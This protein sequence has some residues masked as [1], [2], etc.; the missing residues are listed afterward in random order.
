[1]SSSR[2]RGREERD[3]AVQVFVDAVPPAPAA[4]PANS[5]VIRGHDETVNQVVV[6]PESRLIVTAC[7][8]GHVRVFALDGDGDA[9]H[10]LDAH[11]GSNLKRGA[12]GLAALG[13][14]IIASAGT[15]DGV[16]STWLASSGVFLE[17]LQL[18]R[19]GEGFGTRHG[20]WTMA[21][22]GEREDCLVTSGFEEEIS[23]VSHSDGRKLRVASVEPS[24]CGVIYTISA[25]RDVI[26]AGGTDGTVS[27]FSAT[28]CKVI[29]LLDGHSD[30]TIS[31]AV[32]DRYIAAISI[33]K[34]MIVY[35]NVEGYHLVIVPQLVEGSGGIVPWEGEHVTL[36]GNDL[37]VSATSRQ[38]EEG[39]G[40]RVWFSFLPASQDFA[41]VDVY[42]DD[43][44]SIAITA[45]GTLACVGSRGQRALIVTP[46]APVRAAIKKHADLLFGR[47]G[48]KSVIS[49]MRLRSLGIRSTLK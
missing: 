3:G 25:Q 21:A 16:V 19:G 12:C 8:E 29:A 46:P 49:F 13:G 22:V 48:T 15:D 33:S 38:L 7:C 23:F 36:V 5:R 30:W 14:D 43:I 4:T 2:K 9:L 44:C 11:S 1:M 40:S 6:V 10:D 18:V 34:T 27:I 28:T 20:V 24:G 37:L 47:Y 31:I 45:D 35:R 42:I 39:G 17:S 32:S 41:H 26:V